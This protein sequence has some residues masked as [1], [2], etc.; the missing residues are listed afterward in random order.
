MKRKRFE[1]QVTLNKCF[2][3]VTGRMIVF[4]LFHCTAMYSQSDI[5]CVDLHSFLC[6]LLTDLNVTVALIMTSELWPE[7]TKTMNSLKYENKLLLCLDVFLISLSHLTVLPASEWR[8]QM[9][10]DHDRSETLS[11]S[12]MTSTV[13]LWDLSNMELLVCKCLMTSWNT[14]ISVS[15]K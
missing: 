1:D 2:Y 11:K 14:K 8:D 9:R 10:C 13:E 15:Q 6:F 4:N 7:K 3:N 5:L 12:K